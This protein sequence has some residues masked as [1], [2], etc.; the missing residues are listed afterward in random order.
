MEGFEEP[1]PSGAENLEAG[2]IRALRLHGVAN[3]HLPLTDLSA[4]PQI[5]GSWAPHFT[6]GLAPPVKHGAALPKGAGGNGR[7]R[8]INPD[9]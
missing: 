1:G 5:N 8:G 4:R 2:V 9:V 7:H 3:E 6:H